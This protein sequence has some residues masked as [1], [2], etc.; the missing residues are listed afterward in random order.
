M[1]HYTFTDKMINE[2]IE[3]LC[4]AFIDVTVWNECQRKRQTTL[5]R[6]GQVNR[7]KRFYLLRDFMV[8]GHCGT[9]MGAR[10]KISKST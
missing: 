1:G 5:K 4:P 9:T 6:K 8:C 2:T 3:V 7:A 10:T